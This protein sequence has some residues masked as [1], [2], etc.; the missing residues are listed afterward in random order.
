MSVSCSG[1]KLPTRECVGAWTGGMR[2]HAGHLAPRGRS[3]SRE[4]PGDRRS[5]HGSAGRPGSA[6]LWL[7]LDRQGRFGETLPIPVNTAKRRRQ[8]RTRPP[9][10]RS[11]YVDAPLVASTTS[12]VSGSESGTVVCSASRCSPFLGRGPVWLFVRSV[13]NREDVLRGTA[14]SAGCSDPR[15]SDCLPLLRSPS[16]PQFRCDVGSDRPAGR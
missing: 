6:M 3:A 16:C 2:A 10:D 9:G 13:P 4:P 15:L 14:A 5:T 8:S 7:P 12:N 11:P 1:M